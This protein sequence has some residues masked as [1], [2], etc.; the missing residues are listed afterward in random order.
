MNK[1]FIIVA[2]TVSLLA[3][4]TV[5]AFSQSSTSIRWEYTTN[6]YVPREQYF[7]EEANKLG[8]QGWE[9]VAIDN[10]YSV[11]KRRLP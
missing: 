7:V 8:Q 4:V 10:G 6:Y 3:L 2:I 9:L 11:Y 1:I 5:F